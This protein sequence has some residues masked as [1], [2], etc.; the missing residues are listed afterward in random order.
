MPE[1]FTFNSISESFDL[2]TFSCG[3]QDLDNYLKKYSLKNDI[4]GISKTYLMLEN[5]KDIVGYFSINN[6]SI[7]YNSLSSKQRYRW[8]LPKYEIPC[9]LISRLA[10]QKSKH[11]LGLG[12]KILKQALHQIYEISK[13]IGIYLI[14]VDAIDE[15]AKSFYLKYGFALFPDN[16]NRLFLRL[17]DYEATLQAKNIP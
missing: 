11:G 3:N 16:T 6:Y 10:I 9:A 2:E 15:N 4:A 13:N 8:E 1:L 14:L 17:V 7:S 5:E 12:K